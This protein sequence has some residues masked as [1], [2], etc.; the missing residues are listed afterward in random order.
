MSISFHHDPQVTASLQHWRGRAAF[1][2]DLSSSDLRGLSSQLHLRSVFSAR[3]TNADYLNEVASIVDK[4]LSGEINLATG[5]LALM[6]KL[7]QLG[8]NPETGFP[9]DMAAIPPAERGSLRDISSEQRIDLMLKTNISVAR[10]Y[11]RVVDGNTEAARYSFP[12]WELT[13]TGRRIVPRG[14][15]R[16][17]DGALLPDPE[18][19]WP[20]RWQQAGESVGFEG[21]AKSV[22]IALKDSPI[23]Q[24]LAD[25]VGGYTDTLGHPFP[26]F[27]FNS[28]MGWLG[29]RRAQA[30]S[31]GLLAPG[32]S[33]GPMAAQL[34]PTK[35]EA[36]K[37]LDSLG[38]DFRKRLLAELEDAA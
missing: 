3:T 35:R 23:W 17:E 20:E 18:N 16:G 13:R 31:L 24:A 15:R 6:K 30:E 37:V 11:G 26:P 2:T 1:P 21:A 33:T 25:G 10:N 29:V 22:M 19:A 38:P 14:E 27:A 5:R 36:K 7:K 4:M 28:G 9:Q 8:Y 34:S 12:A 32:A